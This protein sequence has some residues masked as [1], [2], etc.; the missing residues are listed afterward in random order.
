MKIKD[1][2]DWFDRYLKLEFYDFINTS[3]F[4]PNTKE[5]RNFAKKILDP[6]RRLK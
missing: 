6:E 3:S 1:A 2:R 4:V 5:V